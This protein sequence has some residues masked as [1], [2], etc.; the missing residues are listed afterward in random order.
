L[1]PGA[2]MAL[3][4][5][6]IHWRKCSFRRAGRR[7][8][9]PRPSLR[10][11]TEMNVA[12]GVGRDSRFRRVG[13]QRRPGPKLE[14]RQGQHEHYAAGCQQALRNP[15]PNPLRRYRSSPGSANVVKIYPSNLPPYLTGKTSGLSRYLARNVF[16]FRESIHIIWLVFHGN[17][18]HI[19][20]EIYRWI[21]QRP[22]DYH[23]PPG[24]ALF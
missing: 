22:C 1:L 7:A 11:E 24:K 16:Q 5:Q 4:F 8:N 3:I 2:G 17:L 21:M 19:P 12:R 15:Q 6:R 23:R 20:R 10:T 14:A 13:W 9:V 18:G